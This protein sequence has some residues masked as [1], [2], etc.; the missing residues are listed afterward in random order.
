[1]SVKKYSDYIA[2]HEQKTKTIGLRSIVEFA[3]SESDRELSDLWHKHAKHHLLGLKAEDNENDGA[4]EKHDK[5]TS[6]IE[7]KV[8]DKYG[9]G[10]VVD[11]RDHSENHAS[12]YYEKKHNKTDTKDGLVKKY[13]TNM[14]RLR[15]MHD[16]SDS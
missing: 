12:V 5:I 4:V 14:R 11:M 1:M 15:G 7:N 9:H 13:E 3:K 2:L 16:I 10:V 8:H 6:D